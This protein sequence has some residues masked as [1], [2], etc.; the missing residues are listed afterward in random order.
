MAVETGAAAVA[1]PKAISLGAMLMNLIEPHPGHEVGYNRWYEE[2]H[3][4][5]VLQGPGSIAGAR[6]VARRQEKARRHVDESHDQGRGAL[7]TMYWFDGDGSAHR[8]WRAEEGPRLEAAGRVY[9][10]RDFVFGYDGRL[11]FSAGRDVGAVPPELALDR[12]F[13]HLGL[14]LIELSAGSTPA[15]DAAAGYRSQCVP[16]VQA[17][18]SPVALCMGFLGP[19]VTQG[20]EHRTPGAQPPADDLVVFWFCDRDPL[21]EWEHLVAA[22]EK[23]VT[24]AGVGRVVWSSPFL[25]TVVGT[26]TYMDQLS[27]P[28]GR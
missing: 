13:P 6:F 24:A 17:P 2:D 11:A 10:E 14:S 23:G 28:A 4:Y 18:G 8:A 5:A 20:A 1:T 16:L 7:L 22:H 3:L 12:R 26:D 25:A 21:D 19:R 27:G 9:R 15:D